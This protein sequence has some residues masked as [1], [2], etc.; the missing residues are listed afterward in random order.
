[1]FNFS[2]CY[3]N[4]THE[5]YILVWLDIDGNVTLAGIPSNLLR[6]LQAV[7]NP[8][9]RTITGRP[10]SVHIAM[11]LAGK[12]TAERI[13]FKLATLTYRCLHCAAPNNNNNNNNNVE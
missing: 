9:A 2:I 3:E 8:S 4:Q 12:H 1:L 6:R 13:R 11:S 10:H 7:L 5:I